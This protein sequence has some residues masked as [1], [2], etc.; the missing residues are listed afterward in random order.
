[1]VPSPVTKEIAYGTVFAELDDQ[2]G[3]IIRI[4]RFYERSEFL[5]TLLNSRRA[6]PE[7]SAAFVQLG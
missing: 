4:K 7:Q 2:S 5:L 6:R 3:H 1:M